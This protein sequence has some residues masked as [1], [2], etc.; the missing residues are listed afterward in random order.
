MQR[1]KKLMQE[2]AGATDKEVLA[3]PVAY[4]L[5][6]DDQ[7][8]LL[9]N[10]GPEKLK[11]AL[12]CF[13]N[14]DS[15]RDYKTRSKQSRSGGSQSGGPSGGSGSRYSGSTASRSEYGDGDLQGGVQRRGGSLSASDGGESSARGSNGTPRK[16]AVLGMWIKTKDLRAGG[17]YRALVQRGAGGLRSRQPGS[18]M[19][20][21]VS[22]GGLLTGEQVTLRGGLGGQDFG[23]LSMGKRPM[24]MWQG[25]GRRG[26]LQLLK[27]TMGGQMFSVD[28][29]TAAGGGPGG[30]S[31][32]LTLKVDPGTRTIVWYDWEGEF[33]VGEMGWDPGEGAWTL[34]CSAASPDAEDSLAAKMLLTAIGVASWHANPI[35]SVMRGKLW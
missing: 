24:E 1:F 2:S 16:E 28:M 26:S 33:K 8:A 4:P 20:E 30:G 34:Q 18:V 32:S 15:M 22:S 13:Q 5:C 21:V 19:F 6:D 35:D 23:G 27:E 14:G 25:D 11:L 17:S 3:H 7:N 10:A 29:G 9:K 12:R 31:S